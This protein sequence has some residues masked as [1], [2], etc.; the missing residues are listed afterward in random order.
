M[1]S[2]NPTDYLSGPSRPI[3]GT[4]VDHGFPC[5]A[6]EV[7]RNYTVAPDCLISTAVKHGPVSPLGATAALYSRLSRNHAVTIEPCVEGDTKCTN[8]KASNG[9]QGFVETPNFPYADDFLLFLFLNHVEST[10]QEGL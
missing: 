2:S 5:R 1:P 8:E 10:S 9:I 7:R 4:P 3:H 6:Q